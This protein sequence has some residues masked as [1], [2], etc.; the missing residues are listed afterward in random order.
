MTYCGGGAPIG[1]GAPD[2]CCGGGP[3]CGTTTPGCPPLAA[4]ID[5]RYAWGF[6]AFGIMNG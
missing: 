4:I 6:A 3:V 2:T 5:A 1:T